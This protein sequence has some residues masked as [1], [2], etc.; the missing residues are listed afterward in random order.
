MGFSPI[1]KVKRLPPDEKY[2][3]P[4]QGNGG[5]PLPAADAE[6]RL[7]DSHHSECATTTRLRLPSVLPVAAVRR[8][9][10]ANCTQTYDAD[11]VAEVGA[12][13]SAAGTAV[14]A[15]GFALPGGINLPTLN[16]P[17]LPSLPSL[18]EVDRRWLTLPVAALAVFAVLTLIRGDETAPSVPAPA[19]AAKANDARVAK[20]EDRAPAHHGSAKAPAVP[21]D[22]QLVSESTFSLA[23]PP[24]WDRVNPSSGATFGAVSSDGTADATLWIQNDPKLDMAT[25]EANSL[26]QLSGL[27]GSAKVV[28]RELG[29]TAEST[30]IT[31]APAKASEGAPTYEVVLRSSG[32]NWYYLATT[33]QAT[34]PADAIAGVDLIQGS[35]LP[36]GGKG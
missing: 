26:E 15:G 31:L 21:A 25:F 23:M 3:N 6:E 35:F 19:T 33:S 18:D 2:V 1:L 4:A 29:P 32:N 5:F 36:V 11:W 7:V 10:C 34:A 30:S 22:A 28:D 20:V 12:A 9:V 8:V 17:S 13:S 16:R 24:G 27:A 14:M